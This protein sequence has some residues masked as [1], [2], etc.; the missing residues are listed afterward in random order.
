MSTF[1]P[2]PFCLTTSGA[3]QYG[4]PTIVAR[5]NFWSASFA[6]KSKSAV[7]MKAVKPGGENDWCDEE[8]Y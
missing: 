6:Q 4:V 1:A 3:I 8:T 2:Y 7:E 5:L